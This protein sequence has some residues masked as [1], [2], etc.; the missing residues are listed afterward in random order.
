MSIDTNIFSQMI[1]NLTIPP[2][3][4]N[5]LRAT[6]VIQQVKAIPTTQIS[7]KCN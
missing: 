2:K 5:T 4:E 3:T 6:W 7:R 1:L